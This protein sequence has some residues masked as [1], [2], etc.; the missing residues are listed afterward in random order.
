MKTYEAMKG[1]VAN[2]T[3]CG[4]QNLNPKVKNTIIGLGITQQ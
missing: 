3:D 4:L 1:Y 2:N